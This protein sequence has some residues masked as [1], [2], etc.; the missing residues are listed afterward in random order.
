[1]TTPPHPSDHDPDPAT[2]QDVS[3][4]PGA[5]VA[6]RPVGHDGARVDVTE[7]PTW[8]AGA[9]AAAATL[10]VT[11]ILLFGGI[12]LAIWGIFL[13]DGNGDGG[14][15]LLT[16]GILAALVSFILMPMIKIISPGH[17][18]VVQFFGR[19]LGTNRR[20]GLSLI[21]PLSYSTKVSVRVRNFETSEIKVND[22]GGNP[23]MIGAIIVWQVADTAK[24]T[25]SV[26]DVEEFIQSQSESALRHVATSH[27]YDGG[28]ANNPSLSGSTDLVSRELADEVAARVKVAGLEILEA[29]ISAL[30]YAPEIAQSMLQRQQATAIVDAR[31]TIVDGAVS[32]VE[33]ALAEL[34]RKEIVDLDPERRAAM[35]SNLLVVLCSDTNA[36]PMINTGSLYT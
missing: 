7:Q 18:H 22:L 33:S 10:V 9:G 23:V 27:P 31:E 35:V 8:T 24:A 30:S 32:M 28:T 14:P 13:M 34:E 29:R 6:D 16:L 17:T 25:F 5:E 26:E 2:D 36:Q 19:Y 4:V 3:P 20:T 15:A 11:L 12:G 1:M 21:P